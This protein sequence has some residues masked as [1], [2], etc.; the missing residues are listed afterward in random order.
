MVMSADNRMSHPVDLPPSTFEDLIAQNTALLEQH[1]RR[2][3]FQMFTDG[4]LDDAE[5]RET[6]FACLQ[7][8]ARHFQTILFTRQAHCADERYG[9]LF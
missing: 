7:V 8:F 1:K 9:A 2:R 6:F 4:T 3:A 5:K